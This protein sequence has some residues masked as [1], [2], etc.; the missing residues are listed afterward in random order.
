MMADD[1]IYGHWI[2]QGFAH[3]I[4]LAAISSTLRMKQ[5]FLGDSYD[6]IQNIP[7]RFR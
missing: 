5:H 4:K 2:V 3:E 1:D 6:Q 7:A